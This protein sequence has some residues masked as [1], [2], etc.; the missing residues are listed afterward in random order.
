M[1]VFAVES[2]Y[3]NFKFLKGFMS[4]NKI[5][6]SWKNDREKIDVCQN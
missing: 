2:F 5:C 4:K 1:H 6:G 3:F